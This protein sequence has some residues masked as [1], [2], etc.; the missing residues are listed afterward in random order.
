M[1]LAHRYKDCCLLHVVFLG[2]YI[3][4]HS[5]ISAFALCWKVAVKEL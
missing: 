5:S 2:V 4:I 3:L 1:G